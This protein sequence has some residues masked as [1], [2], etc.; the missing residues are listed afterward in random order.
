MSIVAG[1]V[2]EENLVRF[3]E[4]VSLYT[5]YAYD[6][7]DEVALTGV[8]EDTNDDDPPDAWFTYPLSGTPPLTV[9]LA[10]S[11]GGGGVVSIRVAGGFDAVLAARIETLFDLL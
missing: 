7:L 4:H 6:H 2:F 1:W 8:L 5:G 11:D 10:R 9:S 3:L